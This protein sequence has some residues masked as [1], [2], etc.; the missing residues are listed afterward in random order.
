[1]DLKW[2]ILQMKLLNNINNNN[3][4]WLDIQYNTMEQKRQKVVQEHTWKPLW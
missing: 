4:N 2:A 3:N 1:M